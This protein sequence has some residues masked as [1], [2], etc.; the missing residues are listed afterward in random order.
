MPIIESNFTPSLPF[1]NSH[2]NTIYR[3]LFMKETHN[4]KRKRITTWDNDFI[5]LDFSEVNS[6]KIVILIHGLEGSSESKYILSA[7]TELNNS[8]FDTVS[9]NLRGCSGDDNLLLSTYH[10]GKTEDLEFVISYLLKNYSY[11]KIMIVGYSLGGN[12]T[13]KYFGEYAFSI[14]DKVSCGIAVSVPIDLAFS[15][16]LMSSLKNKLYM[17]KF[18]KSL[19]LKVFE[20]SQ[21]HPQY[22]LNINKLTKAKTFKDFDGLYTA[23]IFGFSSP[24]EYWKKASSK[25]YLPKIRKPTLLI[26]SKDDPFLPKECYPYKEAKES[27][28]FHL[29]VTKYGGHV[30]F[31]SSFLPQENRWLEN[32]ILNFL[33]DNS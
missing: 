27:N 29:E 21:K 23:P 30:G 5:D 10:S 25:P 13:L 11:D 6:N 7:A 17:D 1:K 18:L 4:Y 9:F 20:K 14:S 8:G 31:I 12:I 16:E 3:P 22:K 26:S 32:R 19:R 24:E 28:V 2:F 33:E 15:S